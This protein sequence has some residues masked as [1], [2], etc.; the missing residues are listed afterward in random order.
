MK[1]RRPDPPPLRTALRCPWPAAAAA[2]LLACGGGQGDRRNGGVAP[3][4]PAV[5]ADFRDEIIY[6]LLTD[7]FLNG[8]PGND[9]GELDRRG[10]ENVAAADWSPE[11]A[12]TG[13]DTVPGVSIPLAA[14]SGPGSNSRIDITTA[15]CYMFALDATSSSNPVLTVSPRGA[16]GIDPRVRIRA[17][18]AG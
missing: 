15:D 9:S 3:P 18:D 1:D 4:P 14:A 11:F 6:Q 10:D 7:R 16:A 2:L 8:D 12:N 17:H 13:Q 5:T